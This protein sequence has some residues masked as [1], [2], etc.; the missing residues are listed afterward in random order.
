MRVLYLQYVNPLYHVFNNIS[1]NV[2][3]ILFLFLKQSYTNLRTKADRK[4]EVKYQC[5]SLG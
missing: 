5:L 1:V 4:V 3:E 2:C